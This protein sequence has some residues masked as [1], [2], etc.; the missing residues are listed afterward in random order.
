MTKWTNVGGG[1]VIGFVLL[2]FVPVAIFWNRPLQPRIP[3]TAH[4]VQIYMHPSIGREVWPRDTIV[5]VTA[6]G[7]QGST[8]VRYTEDRCHIGDVVNAWQ[9]GINVE[10]DP[11]TCRR[12]PSEQS[13]RSIPAT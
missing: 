10:V 6:T 5:A 1:L 2:C 3:V 7:Q 11:H 4:V 12:A 9:Q 8:S 13:E